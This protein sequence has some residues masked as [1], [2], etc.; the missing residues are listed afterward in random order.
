MSNYVQQPSYI[1]NQHKKNFLLRQSKNI[2]H[3][4]V[5]FLNGMKF[6]DNAEDHPID[7]S[8]KLGTDSSCYDCK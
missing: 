4:Y 2:I 6:T 8:T 5:E 7:I 3:L 1:S